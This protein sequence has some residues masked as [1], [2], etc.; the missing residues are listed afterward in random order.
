[1][2]DTFVAT[3]KFTKTGNIIFGKNS[4][5]EPNEAQALIRIPERR[6]KERMLRTTYIEI[7][8]VKHTYEVMLSKPFQMWG[9]EMGA[10]AHGLVIGNEAVFTKIKIPNENTGLT[11]MDMLRLALERCKTAGDALRLITE[12]LEQYG[13]NACGGY[14][15]R[16]FFYHNSFII[17]DKDDAWV[18]ETAGKHWAAVKAE[19]FRS[20]SNG[21]TIEGDFDLKSP[22]LIDFAKRQGWIKKGGDFSFRKAYSD[23]FYTYFSACKFRQALSTTLGGALNKTLTAESAMQ[24]LRSHG[25][26]DHTNFDPARSGMKALCVHAAGI[27][28]PSQTT[29]SLV[30]ELRRGK[31]STYWFTGTAAPCL[32]LFKPF[33]IPG[34]NFTAGDVEEPGAQADGSLWWRHEHLHRRV[35]PAYAGLTA[36]FL[37]ERDR[38]QQDFLSEEQALMRKGSAALDKFSQ[39]CVARGD[40]HLAESA[41]KL[42]QLKPNKKFHPL[43]AHYWRQANK[44]VNIVV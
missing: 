39:A 27:R 41:Q 25:G 43:Y 22:D 3:P 29:G 12:L 5:R 34:K 24:I 17:A 21:L 35:L 19:G 32:S 20:I 18:L 40:H 42:L 37:S 36:G 28:T 2:C 9:A 1:M 13:Q 38:L 26:T 14:E 44:K 30:A 15:N 16:K 31:P 11:G 8:Q 7:P 23:R 6:P 10:N 33:F 4:D